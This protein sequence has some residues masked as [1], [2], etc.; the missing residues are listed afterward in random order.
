MTSSR[1]FET[2]ITVRYAECDAMAIAHHANYLPWFEVGRT[3]LL[4]ACGH[5]Y[6]DLER[7]GF[8][9]PLA[10]LEVAY[11]R[12]VRYDDRLRLVTRLGAL[13]A[14]R[15]EFSYELYG[16][17]GALATT[18]LTRHAVT[19]RDGRITRLPAAPLASLQALL[20]G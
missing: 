5:R 20:A 16:A 14:V 9:L 4:A 2:F 7:E 1:P 12:P 3:E 15:A 10:G 8:F 6:R 18:A 11:R 13:S 19:G 17:D